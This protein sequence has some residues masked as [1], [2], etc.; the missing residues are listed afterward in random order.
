FNN[1]QGQFQDIDY[2]IVTPAS[3]RNQA[4]RLANFHRSYSSLVVKVVSLQNIY[5]EFGSGKQDIGAIRNFIKYVYENAST[6]AEKVQFVNLFGDASFDF[7]DRIPNNTNLVPIFHTLNGYSIS[8]SSFSSDDFFVLMDANEGSPTL[9]NPGG[10][11]IAVGRMIASGNTQAEQLVTKVIEYH[12]IKSYGS[13]RNNVVLIADDIDDFSDHT[14]Q[15]NQDQI[16]GEISAAKPFINMKKIYLDAYEQETSAGGN[17]YPK[18]R[19][20]VFNSFE[21]GALVFNY[22]GHGGED[23]LA[24]ERIWEKIDGQSLQNRYRYPLFITATCEFSRFDNPYRPTAGEYTYWNPSGGA[25]SMVTTTRSIGQYGA[26]IF[27]VLFAQYLFSY[28]VAA[29]PQTSIAEALRRAKVDDPSTATTVIL[30]LGDP[31]L[32]LALPRPKVRLT[33]VNDVP[34]TGTIDNLEA[35]AYVKLSGEILDENDN[36]LPTY[37][38]ELAVTIFDKPIERLTLNNDNQYQ[39]MPFTVLGETVFRGNASVENGQ[40]E[41]GFVVPRD[42]RIPVGNGRASFYAK[43]D[44]VLLDKSGF[45]TTIKIGGLNENAVADNIGPKVKLYMNDQTFVSGGIT[46]ESPILLAYLEDEHGINTASGIGHDITGVLDGNESNP[47]IM[48]DYYE[49]ELDDYTKGKLRFPLRDL[50][51][52]LHTL[53]FKA[54]D[55]YN[56]PITAEIQFVV[57]GDDS[58]TL[59]NVLNYPNPFVNYTQF[60]FTHNRPAEPLEVQV[61]VLT[62]TGKVVWTKNQIVYSEGFLSREITWD[63]KDDFGDR[64]GKGVY[65]YKLTVKSNVTGSKSE[66]YEKL[67]IL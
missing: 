64:I 24:L 9:T 56:N 8:E 5:Q 16:A 15:E 28:G 45:D 41:F 50:A 33:K 2:I 52:G 43:R 57:T 17:R 55:V 62:V 39:P 32:M 23:G 35:L 65:I 4:E 66:K 29:G 67:V 25:I 20:D 26:E 19:Q 31:A 12:D 36:P 38:G 63:G 27:N 49:T 13:W 47:F 40:F 46:N 61:Q 22:L 34:I 3:L 1:A 58:I 6:V 51:K 60:W 30:Y 59:T 37:K 48:N 44:Q 53:T 11:D 18:A 54:W 21:K 10:P 7:K 14:L 42:I